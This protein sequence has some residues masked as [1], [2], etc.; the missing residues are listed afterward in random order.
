MRRVL[1]TV[2]ILGGV[3][4]IL[5]ALLIVT[6][7][8]LRGVRGSSEC[9]MSPPGDIRRM[10]KLVVD[11]ADVAAPVLTSTTVVTVS[12][13]SPLVQGLFRGRAHSAYRQSMGC[14]LRLGKNEWRWW[15]R[16]ES[17]P[18]VV[19][20][21][22][23][24]VISDTAYTDVE[25]LGEQMQSEHAG[26]CWIPGEYTSERP[27][28]LVSCEADVTFG[29]WTLRS[30]GTGHWYFELDTSVN[31]PWDEVILE[32]P[33]GWLRAPAP[34]PRSSSPERS[35]W[36]N[37]SA[38][39]VFGLLPDMDA[40]GAIAMS[41]HPA[42]S[43]RVILVNGW[44]LVPLILALAWTRTRVRGVRRPP[45]SDGDGH[46]DPAPDIHR[47]E[48]RARDTVEA[49][50]RRRWRAGLR[51]RFLIV[52]CVVTA[53]ATAA[54]V[55]HE[56]LGPGMS[57]GD[58][59]FVYWLITTG[60]LL[61]AG[62]LV[63]WAGRLRLR[64]VLP[65]MIVV[66]GM[67]A[68]VG[69]SERLVPVGEEDLIFPDELPLLPWSTPVLIV[70][71]L[72]LTLL[73][74]IAALNGIRLAWRPGG[75]AA[76]PPWVWWL[77]TLGAVLTVVYACY[78]SAR[79]RSWAGWLS[80]DEG[81]IGQV[82]W[83]LVWLPYNV[84][85]WLAGGGLLWIWPLAYLTALLRAQAAARAVPGLPLWHSLAGEPLEVAR[86]AGRRRRIVLWV[87]AA[88]AFT[89]SD[90][91]GGLWL[92]VTITT[93]A[94]AL[95]LILRLSRSR[96]LGLRRLDDGQLL[97]GTLGHEQL[98][99]AYQRAR[100]FLGARRKGRL[101]DSEREGPPEG[102]ERQFDELRRWPPGQDLRLPPDITPLHLALLAGPRPADRSHLTTDLAWRTGLLTLS[103]GSLP[104]LYL[105]WWDL[106]A[107]GG[108]MNLRWISGLAYPSYVL[109]ELLFWFVPGYLLGLLWR[110]LP[111]RTGP[112]RSL[113]LSGAY[114]T[115][116]A[117]YWA[118]SEIMDL[119][120]VTGMLLRTLLLFAVLTTAGLIT[121][122]RTL[123]QVITPWSRV[124]RFLMD[125]YRLESFPSQATFVLAQLAA[126]LAIIQF[127]RGQGGEPQYP[128]IDPFQ[129]PRGP[130]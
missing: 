69:V 23:A 7:N 80:Y 2:L 1:V 54:V 100:E 78:A 27:S 51:I 17:V 48:R 113:P 20:K 19:V 79:E 108:L 58:A 36:R 101:S 12:R 26:A 83:D 99:Q 45:P 76:P 6:A 89:F 84:V 122:V 55:A 87:F 35:V 34:L 43:L 67:Y 39:V 73:L 16:R 22:D 74:L 47:Q 126:V 40:R 53:L 121:D 88:T 4:G 72:L 115:G 130:G 91:Y 118:L 82:N 37:P 114:A 5:T 102:L 120:D 124:G 9:S 33:N 13:R 44:D 111:G 98:A 81:F 32:L 129:V 68:G 96:V 57:E 8:D 49:R 95:W 3:A 117:A 92:P 66:A 24:V 106:R 41:A 62:V 50:R 31:A 70:A 85:W 103:L 128:S 15:E 112:I 46:P 42:R 116:V 127:V 61:A 119:A 93:G 107:D 109:W 29:P 94:A 110:E 97:L 56:W 125:V 21:D 18:T 38:P 71:G 105:L 52:P 28:G 11:N 64:L 14:L 10:A 123:Q 86:L 65:V 104:M 30:P 77:A 63:M 75:E 59:E 25:S 60:V 90:F